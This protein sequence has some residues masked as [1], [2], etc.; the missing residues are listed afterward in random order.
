MLGRVH[1]VRLEHQGMSIRCGASRRTVLTVPL[2]SMFVSIPPSPA[3]SWTYDEAWEGVCKEGR[4]QSPIDLSFSSAGGLNTATDDREP[5]EMHLRYPTGQVS[6]EVVNNGHGSPQINFKDANVCVE[7]NGE[8]FILDQVH[9]HHPGEHRLGKQDFDMEAHLVHRN[10]DSTSENSILVIGVFLERGKRRCELLDRAMDNV[11][12]AP[13][14]SSSSVGSKDGQGY[15]L[16]SLLPAGGE[17]IWYKGSLTTPPCT[18]NVSWL[19]GVEPVS[20]GPDQLE[21][22]V[23]FGDMQRNARAVQGSLQ[24]RLSHRVR[25]IQ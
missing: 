14:P 3:R 12:M 15:A 11:L 22:F 19:V 23:E 6:G 4:E 18:E 24:N 17:Y 13:S 5:H 10:R 8:T 7:W 2:I 16:R 20:I 1:R 9:F 21:R 25:V